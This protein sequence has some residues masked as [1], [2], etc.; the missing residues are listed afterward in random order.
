M[1]ASS[2][3]RSEIRDQRSEAVQAGFMYCR[4]GCPYGFL[5]IFGFA[6]NRPR[7]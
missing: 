1:R 7:F 6:A 5:L 2:D 4:K 3:Q